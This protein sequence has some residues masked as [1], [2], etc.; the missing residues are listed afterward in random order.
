MTREEALKIIKEFINGTCLHLSDQ[1]ALETLIPELAESEDEKIRKFLIDYFEIIKSTL[2]D[3]G[4]W[5]GFQIEDILA[6]IKKQ[7]EQN[8]KDEECTDFT[9]Y[10]PL[11]NGKGEYECIPY[12]F[13]GS[14]TSFS[15]DKDLIDFLRTCFYTEEEC[16]EWIEQQKES[17]RD[18]IDDFPYSDK[19]KEQKPVDDK[20]F[21]EWID[22]WWKHNK[23]NNPD[24]YNKGDE[25][26]F[27]ERGFKNFCRRIRNMYQQ[28]Q[29]WSDGE[30]ED[31]KRDIVAAIRKYYPTDYAE[32]LTSF[33]KGL[34]PEDNSD[35]E[36]G[37][38]MLCIAYKLMYE[39]IPEN[40]RT[41][42]FWDSLK[43]MREYT[44]KVAIIHSYEHS[45]EWSEEDERMLSRCIKSIECSKQFSDSQTFIE[46][47]DK[48][49]DWLRNRVFTIKQEWSEEDE[50]LLNLIIY[51]LDREEHNGVIT[52]NE[53]KMCVHLLKSLRLQL[54]W[55]P[56]KEQME[57]LAAAIEESNEN[58]VLES[59]YNDLKKLM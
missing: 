26:Q 15:E 24:S 23:V 17:L 41:Q 35:D 56:S 2:S 22:D 7:K 13:Y 21:E 43:F 39:N 16:N 57:Y 33:L 9:I 55:K 59:L 5:K 54:K 31:K 12:S 51:I 47:K 58:P 44:G 52:H 6:Y 45:V 40:L 37:Q 34:S 11:K 1:Q 49:I 38:E 32:Y 30:I 29:E 4:V 42:E 36:Y 19:Q 50:R 53:L 25:I 28:K 10:H 18:F 3:D 14:L 8:G 46:A 20:A 27:D 48:E